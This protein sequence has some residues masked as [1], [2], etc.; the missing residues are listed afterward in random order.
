[1]TT[2]SLIFRDGSDMRGEQKPDSFIT[3]LAYFLT[4]HLLI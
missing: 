4:R 3:Q 1:M 2:P